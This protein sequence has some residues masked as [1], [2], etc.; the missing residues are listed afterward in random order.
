MRFLPGKREKIEAKY[1]EAKDYLYMF[2]GKS[3]FSQFIESVDNF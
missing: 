1:S 2:A 3:D